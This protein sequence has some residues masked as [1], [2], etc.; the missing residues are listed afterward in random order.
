MAVTYGFYNSL[1]KDRMYNAE[2]MSSI[3]NGIITDGV[4]SS[5]GD[6]LMP[7]AG[8]G[9][10][11]IVKPGRAWFNS[12]W[13]LN[14]AQ[15]PLDVPAADVSLT[16]IDAVILEVNSAVA[17]RA[18]SIKV[19][20][21]T[22]SANPAKPALSMTETLHQYALAY[23]TVAAG[24]TSITAANIEINV[25]KTSCPFITSVLQQ[26]DITDLF[27][28]WNAEFTAW[29]ENVQA[30]LS[31]NVAANLQR[32][33]DANTTA[34]SG[35]MNTADKAT[36]ND[37]YSGKSD[38]KYTTPASLGSICEKIGDVRFTTRSVIDDSW[39]LANGESFDAN[40]YPD[41]VA[42][43][44]EG[45]DRF[46]GFSARRDMTLTNLD[47]F[48]IGEYQVL[49]AD[50]TNTNE[51]YVTKNFGTWK[52][53]TLP[54]TTQY[55][56]S[57][58]YINGKYMILTYETTSMASVLRVGFT[59]DL[60]NLPDS[61]VET[62]LNG[63]SIKSTTRY[64]PIYYKG[65]Y[66]VHEYRR[67]GKYYSSYIHYASESNLSTWTSAM[68]SEDD[69]Y[70]YIFGLFVVGDY[71]VALMRQRYDGVD[72]YAYNSPTASN[73]IDRQ[74]M[75][76][77][78]NA[79]TRISCMFVSIDGAL[80][81]TD[82]TAT[83]LEDSTA[84]MRYVPKSA[85]IELPPFN[86]NKHAVCMGV[87][88]DGKLYLLESNKHEV[89]KVSGSTITLIGT[90]ADGPTPYG[91]VH[92]YISDSLIVYE[93]NDRYLYGSFRN[94]TPKITAPAGTKAFIK[95]KAIS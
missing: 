90:I 61:F 77:D 70:Q 32:Q 62:N 89:Y 24:A 39:L 9:M 51:Y 21:G 95:A 36:K 66:I 68:I 75:I 38:T 1:N 17:T 63:T 35:K 71:M 80:Y 20:K 14:D 42:M 58:S 49:I 64:P 76:N 5:I 30:Q 6:A 53:I 27:N 25:G 28:Q 12:T 92:F 69:L 3:F 50:D 44:S 79:V 87:G 23:I 83:S 37:V 74:E 59:N 31:G 47:F 10:Q 65:Y 18:N 82:Y 2:Q 19:L 33:I 54:D 16:R 60:Y 56:K 93:G 48:I 8:T 43:L 91:F 45:K 41:M 84:F 13:T 40:A 22:P 57:I 94:N 55:I 73:R 88:T 52:K 7:I 11:V 78:G 34:I 85:P 15:L 29:F 86:N 67:G 26:T 46:S 81:S 72:V 4:F